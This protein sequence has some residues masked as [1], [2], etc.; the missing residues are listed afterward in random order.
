R[1][2]IADLLEPERLG[3]LLADVD[4]RDEHIISG[5]LALACELA[6]TGGGAY[7]TSDHEV[8]DAQIPGL[9]RARTDRATDVE[10]KFPA[11]LEIERKTRLEQLRAV[12]FIRPDDQFACRVP[13]GSAWSHL[14]A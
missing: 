13:V 7:L 9:D 4:C 5:D 11:D 8:C 10:R 2:H 6:R 1:T 3:N 14:S 12:C